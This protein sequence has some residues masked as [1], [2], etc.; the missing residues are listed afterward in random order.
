VAI[1]RPPQTT[2]TLW[3]LRDG[4]NTDFSAPDDTLERALDFLTQHRRAVP[5]GTFVFLLSDFLQPPS[6]E[7]W[8]RAIEFRWDL[9]P[10]VIQG[11]GLGAKLSA[12]R[13][14]RPPARGRL[15]QRQ[16]GAPRPG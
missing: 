15:G 9:V 8:A 16:A 10:V 5:P 7:A 12:R 2:S 14:D 3:E 13:F 1:W 4:S 11:S 6:A